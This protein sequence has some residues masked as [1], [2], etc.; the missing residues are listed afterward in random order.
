TCAMPHGA[1]HCW[2]RGVPV[3]SGVFMSGGSAVSA[4]GQLKALR[5][6]KGMGL[7]EV[8]RY[9]RQFAD[10]LHQDEYLVSHNYLADIEADRH[11][12]SLFKLYTLSVVYNTELFKLLGLYGMGGEDILRADLGLQ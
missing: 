10:A 2:L 8:E 12:P 9:S 5:E 3:G 6:A 11:K 1:V 4:G 7:R